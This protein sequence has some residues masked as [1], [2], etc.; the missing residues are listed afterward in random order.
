[1]RKWEKK[2][3]T[4]S[5][6]RLPSGEN[7]YPVCLSLQQQKMLAEKANRPQ[8]L[9]LQNAGSAYEA[10]LGILCAKGGFPR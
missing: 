10:L 7:F 8:S 3:S 9:P 1:M 4:F 5:S 2:G 6:V